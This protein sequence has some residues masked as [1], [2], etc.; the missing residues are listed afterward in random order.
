MEQLIESNV[1]KHDWIG[2]LNVNILHRIGYLDT[3]DGI[4][5]DDIANFF[6]ID[7]KSAAWI[8]DLLI[9]NGVLE[10]D[11]MEMHRFT[12]DDQLWNDR[13]TIHMNKHQKNETNLIAKYADSLTEIKNLPILKNVTKTIIK[14]YC[15]ISD[16]DQLCKFFELLKQEKLLKP[17]FFTKFRLYDKLHFSR[18][19]ACVA[20]E[21]DEFLSNRFAYSF[22]LEHLC[23][24][25]DD[26]K[27]D[28]TTPKRLFLQDNPHKEFYEELLSSGIEI[29]SCIS[30]EGYLFVDFSHY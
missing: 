25:L 23:L 11:A 7:F 3:F 8:I 26:S 18:L 21:I 14:Y 4:T 30:Q 15:K 16:Q 22:A 5:T 20:N 10:H 17:I 9:E 2:Q 1:L 28:P 6:D 29:E 13:V 27:V 19:S 12:K 24:G